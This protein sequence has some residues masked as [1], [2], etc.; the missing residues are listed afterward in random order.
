MICLIKFDSELIVDRIEA[1]RLNLTY[2]E[3]GVSRLGYQDKR[4]KVLSSTYD[5]VLLDDVFPSEESDGKYKDKSGRDVASYYVYQP[6]TERDKEKDYVI[7]PHIEYMVDLDIFAPV[8]RY[9]YRILRSIIPKAKG[10]GDIS[11]VLSKVE[12]KVE[13]LLGNVN[14]VQKATFNERCNV[15]VGGGLIV[16]YNDVKLLEDSCSDR[17]QVELNNGWRV[18]AVCVQANQRRPDYVLGRYNP[19]LDTTTETEAKR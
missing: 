17:L 1:T 16:T 13:L 7:L 3:V 14:D 9:P 15:H 12:A 19:N 4:L 8:C 10:E 18:I 2:T 11:D 5:R 6:M